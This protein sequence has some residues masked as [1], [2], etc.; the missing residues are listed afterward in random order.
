M[1]YNLRE[2]TD[3]LFEGVGQYRL[4]SSFLK[5]IDKES[6]GEEVSPSYNPHL[7]K[8]KIMILSIRNLILSPFIGIYIFFY[9]SFKHI[10]RMKNNP[11]DLLSDR[12]WTTEWLWKS[13]DFNE[14]LH[15]FDF[16]KKSSYKVS[17][18][19]LDQF[20]NYLLSVI[21]GTFMFIIST[22]SSFI[23]ILSL[24]KYKI[25][26]EVELFG[27]NLFWWLTIL[28]V[29]WTI[30]H[31]MKI[32]KNATFDPKNSM[33]TL[34]TIFKNTIPQE[35]CDKP[36]SELIV[37][38]F[39]K[40]FASSLYQF[41]FEICSIFVIPIVLFYSVYKSSDKILEFVNGNIVINDGNDFVKSEIHPN[42][43]IKKKDDVLVQSEFSF[44]IN[45]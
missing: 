34:K 25:L 10:L 4:K 45:D 42:S 12:V 20:P 1:I 15:E 43:F 3:Y 31:S 36:S 5:S 7:L 39:K 44:D 30:L 14:L 23:I 11:G 26:F 6:F 13:R 24:F 29:V 16:R 8:S 27:Q 9:F 2:L 38:Q 41:L 33:D 32:D 35:W 17:K 37:S 19:Y 22:M 18:N 21:S 28:I 40:Y